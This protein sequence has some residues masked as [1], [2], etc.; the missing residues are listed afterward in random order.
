MT[1]H[2]ELMIERTIPTKA[3]WPAPN[4]VAIA[5]LTEMKAR[6]AGLKPLLRA[7]AASAEKLRRPDD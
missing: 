2:A 4:G 3:S 6:V 1:I 7:R 5:D